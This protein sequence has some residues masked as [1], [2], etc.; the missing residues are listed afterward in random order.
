M[1]RTAKLCAL[2]LSPLYVAGLVHGANDAPS[3]LHSKLK[4]AGRLTLSVPVKPKLALV[5]V[6]LEP[7]AGPEVM[8]VS[9][10]TE[11][12]T[13]PKVPGLASVLPAAS[14]AFTA[15]V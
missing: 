14:V 11:S 2:R 13:Q 4:F 7:S 9:G 3:R 15:K 12:I 8:L 6:V 1:A 10:L 5:E